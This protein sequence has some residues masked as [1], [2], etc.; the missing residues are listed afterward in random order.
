MS[1]FKHFISGGK[2]FKR[3][4]VANPRVYLCGC[5]AGGCVC[6]AHANPDLNIHSRECD[7]HAAEWGCSPA[8]GLH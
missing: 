3:D 5:C 2:P 8:S 7:A 6:E 4:T 1:G